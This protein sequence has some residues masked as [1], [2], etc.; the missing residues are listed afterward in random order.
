[1]SLRSARCSQRTRGPDTP[2]AVRWPCQKRAVSWAQPHVSSLIAARFTP[3]HRAVRAQTRFGR[4]RGS[5]AASA[6]ALA[7][8]AC[9]VA[10]GLACLLLGALLGLLG[11]ALSLLRIAFGLS[12]VAFC[13]PCSLIC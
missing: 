12:G 11:L 2:A 9:F 4:R 10:E 3:L 6:L 5:G 13:L 8:V 7:V 1:M